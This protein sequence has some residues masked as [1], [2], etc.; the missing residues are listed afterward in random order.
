MLTAVY[1][2]HVMKQ[3]TLYKWYKRFEVSSVQNAP[4]H[5]FPGG[6]RVSNYT[7]HTTIVLEMGAAPADIRTNGI[8]LFRVPGLVIAVRRRI[9]N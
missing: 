2:E 7:R 4:P 8:S 1:F 9:N 5:L 6:G 3:V